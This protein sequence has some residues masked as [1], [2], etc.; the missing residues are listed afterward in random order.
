[1][2]FSIFVVIFSK[3]C[4]FRILIFDRSS[5]VHLFLISWGMRNLS[6][7][8]PIP[9]YS[10]LFH[11]IPPYSGLF[12]AIL[13]YFSLFMPIPA[14]SGLYQPIPASFSQFQPIK[15]YSSLFQPIPAYSGLFQPSFHHH[16]IL[17][18]NR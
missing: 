9:A 1:M 2:V 4:Y 18:F 15:T 12:Q 16:I 17:S 13:A 7:F 10:G 11:P 6:L 5:P 14:Y 3:F 8:Q